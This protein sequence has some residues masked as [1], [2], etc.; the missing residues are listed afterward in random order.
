MFYFALITELCY[1]EFK[2]IWEL[3][4]TIRKTPA[5]VRLFQHKMPNWTR[6]GQKPKQFPGL[7]AGQVGG[8]LRCH[9]AG[10]P[11]S[12][13]QKHAVLNV[14]FNADDEFAHDVQHHIRHGVGWADKSQPGFF[15]PANWNTTLDKWVNRYKHSSKDSTWRAC[16]GVSF[17]L[18]GV[19]GSR[20]VWLQS[21]W[22]TESQASYRECNSRVPWRRRKTP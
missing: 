5:N 18:S 3:F 4:I 9:A 15:S 2:G 16:V 14:T 20:T 11:A 7:K 6:L 17:R 22:A 21:R 13:R 1:G 19:V 10:F 12:W 8:A